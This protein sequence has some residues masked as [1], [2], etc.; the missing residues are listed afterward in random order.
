[1]KNILFMCFLTAGFAHPALSQLKIDGK[2]LNADESIEYIQFSFFYES[3]NLKPVYAI[4]FGSVIADNAEIKP[5]KIE[6]NGEEVTGR[7][8]PAYVLNKLY[9]AGWEYLG[10]AI[11]MPAPMIENTQMFTLRRKPQR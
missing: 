10:D 11:F 6:I 5:Q 1:M 8:T 3:R 4:D 2:D 9:K 7:M